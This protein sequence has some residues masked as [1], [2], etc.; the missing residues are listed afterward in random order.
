MVINKQDTN[1]TKALLQTGELGYDN[2]P[3][4]GDKG[5]VYVGDGTV[6]V[7]L[8]KKSE[9]DGKLDK[10]GGS[11]TGALTV[12]SL[13][14]TGTVDG[15]DVSADGAKLDGIAAGAQVNTVTSVASKTGAVTLVKADV[16]LGNVDNTSD[17]NKPVSTATQTALDLKA[18]LASP[19]FT[20]TVGG[21]TK[22]MVGL[23]SVDNTADSAKVVASAGKWTTARTISLTGGVTG[24]V[25]IDGS[26]NVSMVTTVDGSQHTHTLASLGLDGI[27][28]TRA[29][30]FLAAQN[31]AAMQY[32]GG[33]N[34][35]KI[36]YNNATDVN[37]EVLNYTSGNL[38]SINHYVSGASAG[39]TTLN[40]TGDNLTSV[41]FA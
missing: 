16:G 2:Y 9:L 4:G 36:Q 20:G 10:A 1:G 39:T 24:S 8:A 38:T 34:L 31:I 14:V 3:A 37:Y 11:M 26:G 23:G 6:N 13:I 19:T 5:R 28:L 40:Y 17:A 33:G 35:V 15:R 41:I 21:I 32:D 25:S 18:N 29:D 22:G 7:A 27:N 30:K 12:P